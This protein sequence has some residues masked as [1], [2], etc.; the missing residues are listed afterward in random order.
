MKT[1]LKFHL[2]PVRTT[3]IKK[4]TGN[5]HWR[6]CGEKG[7]LLHCWWECKLVQLLWR[8]VWRFLKKLETELP[9]GP[10]IP[11]LGIHPEETRTERDTRTPMLTAALFTI[12]STWKQPRCPSTDMDKEIVVQIHNG[13]LLSYR[14]ECTWVCSDEVYEPEAYH[15]EWS[16]S[17]RKRQTLYAN[18]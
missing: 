3:I 5:K 4:S 11:L 8:A 7:T 12:A 17:E 9:Y 15:A 13:M 6:G 10:A 16:I 18:A 1:T 14:N 2:T